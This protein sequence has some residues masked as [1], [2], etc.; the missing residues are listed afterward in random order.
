[1]IQPRGPVSARVT[2][3]HADAQ[4]AEAVATALRR[5]GHRVHVVVPGSRLEQDL[6]DSAPDMLVLH[7][8]VGTALEACVRA[9]RR[10]FEAPVVLLSDGGP[11][12]GSVEADAVLREPVEVEVLTV[13]V[14]GLLYPAGRIR[15][16][17]R[18]VQAREALYKISWAFALEAGSQPL[19]GYLSEECA[20]ILKSEIGLVVDRVANA[21]D[22]VALHTVAALLGDDLAPLG[23]GE[24]D[25]ADLGLED[26]GALLGEVPEQ[27]LAARLQ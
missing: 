18:R 7:T 1:V 14:A 2:V 9:V 23:V 13:S 27:R 24:Q 10:A 26:L 3:A 11:T 4:R 25:E 8:G 21:L 15:R 6:V 5:A 22:L 19:F 12:T 20:K 17:R 16:L